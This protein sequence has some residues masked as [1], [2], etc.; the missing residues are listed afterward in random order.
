[1]NYNYALG[2]S[3]IG[4]L[5]I[6]IPQ[7]IYPNRQPT[8]VKEGTEIILGSGN[9]NPN[10][11]VSS[12]IYGLT[13]EFMLNFGYLF[14]PFTFIILAFFIGKVREFYFSLN[15][16]D[17]RLYIYPF[18]VI[19][20]FSILVQDLDNLVYSIVKNLMIPYLILL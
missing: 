19:M 16:R 10:G 13:G 4:D 20:C 11:Y 6:L 3:Y 2:R 5:S 9:Y 1:D 7:R 8:K 15:D 14:A 17:A 18:F 12:R